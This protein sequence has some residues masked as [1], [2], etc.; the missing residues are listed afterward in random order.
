MAPSLRTRRFWRD[1]SGVAAT[2]F[3]VII[4]VLL[5][6]LMG[7]MAIFDLFRTS[8]N[9]EKA[10]FTIGDVLSRQTVIDDQFLDSV[11]AIF[12]RLVPGAAEGSSLR[13]SSIGRNGEA[14]VV[15]WTKPRGD[16]DA[17]SAIDIPLDT[18]PDIAEGN[19]VILTETYLPHRSFFAA[20]G[21]DTITYANQAAYRPRFVSAIAFGN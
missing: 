4:P 10:T 13:V 1:T 2:E 20:V 16:S 3:A 6:L 7:T 5:F 14:F 8:Q 11:Y 18:L 17:L 15:L 19:S 21:I 9:V 12:T